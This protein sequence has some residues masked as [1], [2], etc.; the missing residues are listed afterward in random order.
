MRKVPESLSYV[1]DAIYCRFAQKGFWRWSKAT[2]LW[3]LHPLQV[4]QESF[5]L[6]S[7]VLKLYLKAFDK[8]MGIRFFCTVWCLWHSSAAQIRA[9]F[10][11]LTIIGSLTSGCFFY[12]KWNWGV[13]YCDSELDTYLRHRCFAF[14][15]LCLRY[16]NY[17]YLRHRFAMSFCS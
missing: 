14:H 8:R 9:L 16:V 1:D 4:L 12:Q 17:G 5:F 13:N 10:W 11:L 6:L 3:L 2:C 7:L 15:L